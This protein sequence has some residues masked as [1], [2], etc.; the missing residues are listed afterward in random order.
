MHSNSLRD[1]FTGRNV[2]IGE[3][4]RAFDASRSQYVQSTRTDIDD[5]SDLIDGAV[6]V[7]AK[8]RS[9][10]EAIIG[11]SKGEACGT[12]IKPSPSGVLSPLGDRARYG[13]GE[14]VSAEEELERLAR[15]FGV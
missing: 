1:A 3:A 13:R 8:A 12:D 10:V 6:K 2:P 14:A 9:I 15:S 7:S 4:D 11:Y 5:I